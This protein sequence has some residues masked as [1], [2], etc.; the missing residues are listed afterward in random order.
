MQVGDD[1][2]DTM[3]HRPFSGLEGLLRDGK[4]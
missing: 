2:G 1:E 4:K 3:T